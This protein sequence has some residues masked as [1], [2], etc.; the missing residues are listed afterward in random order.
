MSEQTIYTSLIRA[1]L[2]PEGASGSMG[3]MFAESTMKAN[4]AQRGMT[5]LSY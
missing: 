4:I 5:H 2:T 3:N 1:G